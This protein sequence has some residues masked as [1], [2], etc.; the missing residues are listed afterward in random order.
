MRETERQR[1]REREIL[2]YSCSKAAVQLRESF[3]SATPATP[4]KGHLFD[5]A[6]P[7]EPVKKKNGGDFLSPSSTALS[8][9]YDEDLKYYLALINYNREF[10]LALV[11]IESLGTLGSSIGN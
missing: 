7:P 1:D 5:D 10:Y 4:R 9:I 3:V 6:S 8:R 2:A 11:T